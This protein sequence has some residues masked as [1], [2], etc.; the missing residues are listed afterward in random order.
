MAFRRSTGGPR[1][2]RP[3]NAPAPRSETRY[4]APMPR[5][6][7]TRPTGVRAP[8]RIARTL[9]AALNGVVG[10]H[11]HRRGNGLA[12]E[13]ALVHRD[14]PLSLEREALGEALGA[15]GGR[16]AVWVHGLCVDDG[17]W[18]PAGDVSRS[19]PARLERE[20]GYV[21]LLLR[22][23]SGRHVSEN[24]ELL[25]DLLE[26]LVEA[27]PAPV[28]E[29]LLVGYSMGGLVIRSACHAGVAA[30]RRWPG[31][32]RQAVYLGVPHRGTHYERLGRAAAWTLRTLPNP[33]TRLVASIGDLRSAG[34]QDL[35]HGRLLRGHWEGADPAAPFHA[36]PDPLPLLPGIRHGLI[37]GSLGADERRFLTA[38][39][40]DGMVPLASACA[41]LHR[42]T[43]SERGRLRIVPGV[44]H[45]ALPY[46]PEVWDQLRAWC[47]EEA[48]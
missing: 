31:L 43:E 48:R 45:V 33:I 34:I 14:V 15:A 27:A 22:Y 28:E 47:A 1:T 39:F 2:P 10:D 44:G 9:L 26:R 38:L 37:A 23:N 21:P 41:G 4:L 11:L 19:F 20:F 6:P 46:H 7:A 5:H 40:G 29:L 36:R 3:G 16:W 24:G 17:V 30:G 42:A 13:F 8:A 32:V 18:S 25:A 35:G 12:T